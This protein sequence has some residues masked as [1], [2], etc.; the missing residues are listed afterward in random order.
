MAGN[1]YLNGKLLLESSSSYGTADPSTLTS[2]AVG[3]VYF[4]II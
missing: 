1:I 2:P 4:K 3:Q